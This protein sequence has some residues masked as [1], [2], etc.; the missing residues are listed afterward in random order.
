[1][2]QSFF[3]GKTKIFWS[4]SSSASFRFRGKK[5]SVRVCLR[6]GCFLPSASTLSLV[7]SR[8]VAV[9]SLSEAILFLNERSAA[10]FLLNH[11][12][13]QLCVLSLC[14]FFPLGLFCRSL[15]AQF[16][17]FA[18]LRDRGLPFRGSAARSPTFRILS[19]PLLDG[20][21]AF[22][23]ESG[24]PTAHANGIFAPP[25]FLPHNSAQLS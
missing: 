13:V 16:A 11:P 15:T 2:F 9:G 3:L 4:S 23:E 12:A 22:E 25:P 20:F 14:P 1:M 21:N 6:S 5:K 10:L 17:G 7:G 19:R 18:R 8:A 24:P